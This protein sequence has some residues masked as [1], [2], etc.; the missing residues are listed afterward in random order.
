VS[1]MSE[2]RTARGVV[3]QPPYLGLSRESKRVDRRAFGRAVKRAPRLVA[4][5]EISTS[6]LHLVFGRS[7]AAALRSRITLA[8][9]DS[10]DAYDN[11]GCCSRSLAACC[12]SEPGLTHPLSVIFGAESRFDRLRAVDSSG[13]VQRHVRHAAEFASRVPLR[14][15]QSIRLSSTVDGYNY[16]RFTACW[17]S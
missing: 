5:F 2:G 9:S 3:S 8:P 17:D 10:N 1:R 15:A 16:L 13:N 14:A 12:E 6:L 7:V 4:S 11:F